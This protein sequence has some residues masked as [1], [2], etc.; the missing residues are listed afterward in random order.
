METRTEIHLSLLSHLFLLLRLLSLIVDY[1]YFK[2]FTH[3]TWD[4]PAGKSTS[5]ELKQKQTKKKKKNEAQ[6]TREQHKVLQLLPNFVTKN[7]FLCI[8]SALGD[9][10]IAQNFETKQRASR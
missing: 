5:T 1:Y 3:L 6:K 10:I 8:V 9:I 2:K 4:H 7:N